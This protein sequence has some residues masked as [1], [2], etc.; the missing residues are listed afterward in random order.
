MPSYKSWTPEHVSG[1]VECYQ[2]V[3]APLAT[4]LGYHATG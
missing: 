3:L 1:I 2:V 4:L